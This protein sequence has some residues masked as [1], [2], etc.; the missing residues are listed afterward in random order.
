[1]TKKFKLH[2]K[3]LSPVHIASGEELSPFNYTIKQEVDNEKPLY[4][5]YQINTFIFINLLSEDKRKELLNILQSKDDANILQKSCSFI[6]KEFNYEQ[7]KQAIINTLIVNPSVY[8]NY[9][10]MI[11]TN[12]FENGIRTVIKDGKLKPYIPGSSIKGLLRK[13]FFFKYNI[14][15]TIDI[16]EDPFSL[17]S[18]DDMY[19][20][21]SRGL[22]IG[23][24]RDFNYNEFKIK[25]KEVNY[26]IEYMKPKLTFT[27]NISIKNN[28]SKLKYKDEFMKEFSSI[29]NII[30]LLNNQ[31]KSM[32][33]SDKEKFVS[34]KGNI[35]ISN[36]ENIKKTYGDNVAIINIGRYAGENFKAIIGKKEKDG[37]KSYSRRLFTLNNNKDIYDSSEVMPVGWIAVYEE[38]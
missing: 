33:N 4:K 12:D 19:P 28:M 26:Y 8:K 37:K 13:A 25:D 17:L 32:L 30:S 2:L 10:N 6:F 7:Y 5:M 11:K 27:Y 20:N 34:E 36:V 31:Y 9:V 14:D 29:E 22:G 35:F 3:I 15:K 24:I 18:V 1:M 23:Y 16:N 38:K 21:Q